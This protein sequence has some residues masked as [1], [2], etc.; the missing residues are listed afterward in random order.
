MEMSAATKAEVEHIAAVQDNPFIRNFGNENALNP[1]Q[2]TKDVNNT[3]EKTEDTQGS[4]GDTD[5]E[6]EYH[7]NSGFVNKLRSKFAELEKKR[8]STV[9]S[10]SRRSASVENLLNLNSHSQSSSREKFRHGSTSH[11][12]VDDSRILSSSD[13]SNV[14]LRKKK[15]PSSPSNRSSYER[16]RSNE[17]KTKADKPPFI[18]P[19]I[20]PKGKNVDF[21]SPNNLIRSVKPPVARRGSTESLRKQQRNSATSPTKIEHHDWKVAPDL[22]KIDTDNIVIIETTQPTSP[23]PREVN[24]QQTEESSNFRRVRPFKDKSNKDNKRENELPKPNTV[25]TFLSMF[26]KG[27]MPARPMLAW[28]QNFSPTRKGSDSDA[29]SPRTS[30]PSVT[31]R[32]PL[33]K[34]LDDNVFTELTDAQEKTET[35][36]ENIFF[37]DT[38]DVSEVTLQNSNSIDLQNSSDFN[39]SNAVQNDTKAD[40]NFFHSTNKTNFERTKHADKGITAEV[41]MV[42]PAV[43]DQVP[44]PSVQPG[45]L[46]VPL[47]MVF[48]SHSVA[49]I[50][51][52]MK[53][54]N[55]KRHK[56]PKDTLALK[57]DKDQHKVKSPDT[58]SKNIMSTAKEMKKTDFIEKNA[59]S[60]ENNENVSLASNIKPSQRKAKISPRK[61]KVF[62]SSNM[63]KVNR[64]PPKIPSKNLNQA[65][66]E[67]KAT[68]KPKEVSIEIKD[69]ESKKESSVSKPPRV[70][71][72][73]KKE[74]KHAFDKITNT[75]VSKVQN[76]PKNYDFPKNT[77]NDTSESISEPGKTTQRHG[78]SKTERPVSGVSSFVANRLKKSQEQNNGQQLKT[79]AMHLVNGSSPSPVP[80]KRPA[81]EIPTLPGSNNIEM[82][83][84]KS[85]LAPPPL[86]STPEPALPKTNIDDIINRRNKTIKPMPKMVFDSS[87]MANKRKDPP[88]RK[89]PRKTLEEI[90]TIHTNGVVP[91]LD[92]TSI[93]N[94]TN[95]T[96]YQEGYIPTV[97]QPCPFKF[98]HAEVVPEKSPYKKTKKKKLKISFDDHATTTF[99]YAGEEAALE[100]YLKEH[101]QEREE[102]LRQEEE[103]NSDSVTLEQMNDDPTKDSPR[104]AEPDALRSNTVIGQP[105]GAFTNYKSKMQIDFQF[106]V[107][108]ESDDDVIYE[109]EPEHEVDPDSMQLLPA[110]ENELDTFSAEVSKADMLF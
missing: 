61:T 43:S 108:T 66:K 12:S 29:N 7:V 73:S 70:S 86:P 36:N 49:P 97:I 84:D 47:C 71:Q 31:P 8:N 24:L 45:D 20:V 16:P 80:R 83:E 105:T 81:P 92:L 65:S 58:E 11:L 39:V 54:R 94:E 93:T 52:T 10:F 2:E 19:P 103:I 26:E 110:D 67:N 79:S 104:L 87:K 3:E 57:H 40:T 102:A 44:S 14:E 78:D 100:E 68:E 28:K 59:A 18:K 106:G 1:R 32:S 55:E 35:S 50:K 53:L 22:E 9:I 109:P 63:V 91:K 48:D 88:K 37:K 41:E 6:Q 34:K 5:Q 72:N 56:M 98:I 27:K 99:E 51:K 85:K 96:E 60:N 33:T 90:N 30:S 75:S 46:P 62:D 38:K 64:E 69:R 77:F 89:P 4:N 82:D 21:S 95:E 107:P 15:A 74:T 101:P 23:S 25:S 42:N 76:T 17:L 13:I